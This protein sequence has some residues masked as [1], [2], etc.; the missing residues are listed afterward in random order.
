MPTTIKGNFNRKWVIDLN[1]FNF[2]QQPDRHSSENEFKSKIDEIE[3]RYE[4]VIEENEN[5]RIGMHEILEQ[6]RNYD[7]IL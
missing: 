7:G 3:A 2:F 1:F 4:I 6:L 5:L